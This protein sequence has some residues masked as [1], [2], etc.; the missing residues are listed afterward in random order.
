MM[1]AASMGLKTWKGAGAGLLAVG[2]GMLAGIAPAAAQDAWTQ[3]ERADAALSAAASEQGE[4]AAMQA[5]AAEGAVVF[6]PDPRL[7]ATWADD[8]G[9]RPSWSTN[10]IEIAYYGDLGYVVGGR[11]LEAG[12]SGRGEVEG[13]SL[14]V[15]RIDAAGR[16]QLL[17]DHQVAAEDAR[18]ERNPR[19]RELDPEDMHTAGADADRLRGLEQI[20]ASLLQALAGGSPEPLCERFARDVLVLRRG[21]DPTSRCRDATLP[22]G[23]DPRRVELLG[24]VQ[25]RAG[26]MATT[27][28]GGDGGTWLRVWRL[29]ADG[30]WV[31]AADLM[32]AP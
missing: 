26:D 20:E 9:R 12:G 22:A 5:V 25:S 19:R 3:L 32:R 21:E 18:R 10:A 23:F 14:A 4:R 30:R 27:W 15:W 1:G 2:M 8:G 7:V 28:G 24:A 13:Y 6:R 11:T 29:G 31:I 16:W 17:A